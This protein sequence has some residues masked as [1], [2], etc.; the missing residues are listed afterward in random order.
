MTP[1]LFN[2]RP[3]FIFF[4]HWATW[5]LVYA[6]TFLP[7]ALNAPWIGWAFFCES[8]LVIATVNFLLFYLAAFYLMQKIEIKRTR[9][10]WLS[11]SCL[12]LPVLLTYLKFR[13]S[14]YFMGHVLAD[15]TVQLPASYREQWQEATQGTRGLFSAPFKT[16][17]QTNIYFSFSIVVI[18]I[19]YRSAVAWYLQEKNR[20]ELENQKLRA[21]LSFLVMQVNPHFLFNA[22]NNIY[23]LLVLE[24]SKLAG[25]SILKLSELLRYMLYEKADENNKVALEREIRHI[26]S[27]IDLEKMRRSE[28]VYFNFSIEGDVCTKRVAP[29]LLFP[30]VENSFKHGVLTDPGKPVILQLNVTDEQ[31]YFSL[32]NYKNSHLKD[33]VG[34]I[35]IQNVKKRLELIYG[36]HFTFHET[37]N[38]EV[39]KVKLQLPL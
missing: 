24:N 38:E 1:A 11:I 21:E 32:E 6:I 17:F 16:Y 7:M 36:S 25:N 34:G 26:N 20:R 30:L 15:K 29:L 18:A 22:L 33:T 14:V 31:L 39:Y 23:S 5:L 2:R 9:G 19:A 13:I 12:V 28:R 35:G 10:A 3:L 27:Y 37:Q 8:F 4:A